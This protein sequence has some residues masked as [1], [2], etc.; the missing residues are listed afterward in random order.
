MISLK[1][2]RSYRVVVAICDTDLIGKRFEEGK[3][4]LDCRQ[5]F[6]EDRKIDF[7]DAVKVIEMQSYEDA[8][9]NIVGPN[10][11]KASIEAGII[12]KEDV[13]KIQGIPFALTLV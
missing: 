8:T 4:Q 12:S 11:I 6:Y 3:R 10:S 7:K 1:I 13:D 5:N 9:F 2:H